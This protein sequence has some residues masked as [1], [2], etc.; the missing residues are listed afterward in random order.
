[1]SWINMPSEAI[2]EFSA[3]K[4]DLNSPACLRNPKQLHLMSHIL[5]NTRKVASQLGVRLGLGVSISLL[6]PSFKS[7]SK[8][9]SVKGWRHERL[10]LQLLLACLFGHAHFSLHLCLVFCY[11]FGASIEILP[12]RFG[13]WKWYMAHESGWRQQ[14]QQQHTD[15]HT[16]TRST[17]TPLLLHMHKTII[18]PH[19]LC[20]QKRLKGRSCPKKEKKTY[21]KRSLHTEKSITITQYTARNARVK[22]RHHMLENKVYF[23]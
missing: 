3:N 16:H 7:S 11:Y 17:H 13:E 1:M 6:L 4:A 8:C 18:K 19:F 9:S 15:T 22:S 12:G 21:E 10:L 5:C 14:Q 2:F 20:R 23:G